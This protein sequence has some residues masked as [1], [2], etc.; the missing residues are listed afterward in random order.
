MGV[1]EEIPIDPEE[2]RA[3]VP[4][5]LTLV[6]VEAQALSSDAMEDNEQGDLPICTFPSFCMIDQVDLVLLTDIMHHFNIRKDY[7]LAMIA[8]W[9]KAD[10]DWVVEGVDRHLLVDSAI[11][12][13]E[14]KTGK[15]ILKEIF[16]EARIYEGELASKEE[17]AVIEE[18]LGIAEMGRFT[19]PQVAEDS[20][21]TIQLWTRNQLEAD[22]NQKVLSLELSV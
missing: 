20:K 13:H 3:L 1:D 12:D 5:P 11:Q 8:N 2:E 18:R 17:M 22:E 4:M 15:E 6:P 14:Y 16:E 19:T 21:S 7:C 10:M 9:C